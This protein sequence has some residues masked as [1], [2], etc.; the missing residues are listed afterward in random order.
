MHHDNPF[1]AADF[2]LSNKFLPVTNKRQLI[3]DRN[4]CR[5]I[6]VFIQ[7]HSRLLSSYN[8]CANKYSSMEQRWTDTGWINKNFP[9]NTCPINSLFPYISHGQA[10][11]ATRAF[12]VKARRPP[13]RNKAR[14]N[15][16]IIWCQLV[17]D[18]EVTLCIIHWFVLRSFNNHSWEFGW[19]CSIKLAEKNY[20][21]CE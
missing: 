18:E 10:Y 2:H 9:R 19:F 4:T 17:L 3:N 21:S 13:N 8:V 11:N 20:A 12:A 1:N 5:W 15:W 6:F 7:R 16:W 14:P